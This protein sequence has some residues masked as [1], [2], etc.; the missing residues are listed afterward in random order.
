MKHLYSADCGEFVLKPMEEADIEKMRLLRNRNRNWFVFSGQ[1]TREE[2]K[3]WYQRYLAQEG[4]FLF[5]AF[6]RDRWIGA[7]A[8]YDVADGQAEFGRLLVDRTAA[9]RGGLGTEIT[10]AICQIGFQQLSLQAIYLEV[11]TDNIAA[12]ITYLK[13]GFK[14]VGLLEDSGG[15]KMLRMERISDGFEKAE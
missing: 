4:D 8:L 7:G 15:R 10:S 6:Y 1:I 9:G 11:Y 5:S 3:A 13:A 2:Q 14:A 12:Q